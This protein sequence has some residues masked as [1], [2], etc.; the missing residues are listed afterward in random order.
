MPACLPACLHRCQLISFLA[1]LFSCIF[2]RNN[3]MM[4]KQTNSNTKLMIPR[5]QADVD[6]QL[7]DPK[8]FSQSR[9]HQQHAQNQHC[10]VFAE[11]QSF[12]CILK[13]VILSINEY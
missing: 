5:C 1:F 10:Q 12:C 11:Q 7:T 13:R 3:L 4:T 2:N 6:T 9:M 8:L